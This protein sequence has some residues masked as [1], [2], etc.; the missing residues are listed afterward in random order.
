[1]NNQYAL[2]DDLDLTFDDIEL[3][4]DDKPPTISEHL[5]PSAEMQ[6]KFMQNCVALGI[7]R[8]V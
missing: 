5:R 4:V 6:D 1:M 2:V 3:D 7:L 8:K